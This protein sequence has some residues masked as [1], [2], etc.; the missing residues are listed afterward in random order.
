MGKLFKV[1]MLKLTKYEGILRKVGEVYEVDETTAKRWYNRG[2]ATLT[3]ASLK[4][5]GIASAEEA[6][7]PAEEDDEDA[8]SADTSDKAAVNGVSGN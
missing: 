6:E 4:K 5:L 1:K 7:T 3:K 2:I 8:T